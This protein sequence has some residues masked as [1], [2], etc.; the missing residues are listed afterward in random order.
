MAD[1]TQA[2]LD[3]LTAELSAVTSAVAA[4]AETLV[5]LEV[6]GVEEPPPPPP[7]SLVKPLAPT[8]LALTA[9]GA[10]LVATWD[11][12]PAAEEVDAYQVYLNGSYSYTSVTDPRFV[13]PGAPGSPV[14]V[15]VSAHNAAG[16]GPWGPSAAGTIPG[17]QPPP[18]P[19]SGGGDTFANPFTASPVRRPAVGVGF[20]DP[21]V[22]AQWVDTAIGCAITAN[23]GRGPTI[24]YGE[25]RW[26]ASA[27]DPMWTVIGSQGSTTI[28]APQ[29]ITDQGGADPTIGIYDNATGRVVRL[30]G[31]ASTGIQFDRTNRV[32]R[33]ENIGV[34]D[35]RDGAPNMGKGT[36]WNRMSGEGLM[37]P[38]DLDG[39]Q[40]R[41]KVALGNAQCAKNFIAPARAYEVA[42]K[43]GP[44]PHGATFVHL[45]DEATIRAAC[46][47]TGLTGNALKLSLAFWLGLGYNTG[48]YGFVVGDGTGDGGIN[49]YIQYPEMGLTET[50][51]RAAV[52]IQSLWRDKS[53]WRALVAG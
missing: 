52:R 15:R 21:A 29:D 42:S 35:D 7:P 18:P 10:E 23:D 5:T 36:A 24:F 53:K 16:F 2:A 8:G 27:T 39:L 6:I 3:E 48:G 40:T 32:M 49:F 47:A 1:I 20:Q 38:R 4:V 26:T 13:V 28:H 37:L 34:D 12:A 31:G 30:Y 17:N 25:K 51:A 9:A 14:S 19:A 22:S 50:Q 45:Y 11:A 41:V 46:N 44:V 43:G 33:G